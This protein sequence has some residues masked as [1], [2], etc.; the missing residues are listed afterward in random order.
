VDPT[1][2]ARTF[3]MVKTSVR[4]Q[5]LIYFFRGLATNP[6]A[7]NAMREFFELNYDS[8][9]RAYFRLSLY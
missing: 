6:K 7:I 9:R 2:Q 4:N 8:V 1:L 5:D 3:D